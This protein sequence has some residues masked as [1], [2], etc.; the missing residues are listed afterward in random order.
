MRLRIFLPLISAIFAM[1]LFHVRDKQVCR[2]REN[3]RVSGFME[4]IPDT[5]SRARYLDYAINAPAWASLGENRGLLWHRSTYWTGR[6]LR[7]FLALIV[8]WYWLG[9]Q[10]DKKVRPDETGGSQRGW[11]GRALALACVLYGVFM[12]SLMV[13]EVLFVYDKTIGYWSPLREYEP[14]F[15]V[16]VI[17]WGVGIILAGC[18]SLMSRPA[19]NAYRK[20]SQSG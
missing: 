1:M 12:C 9:S 10:V 17:S 3:R 14:W 18:Y 11:W 2:I 4:P 20:G 6:D 19:R 13:P 8:M 5:Y 15:V 16:A 7:F